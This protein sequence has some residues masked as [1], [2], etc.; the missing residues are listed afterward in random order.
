MKEISTL[1]ES[2]I[3]ADLSSSSKLVQARACPILNRFCLPPG[4]ASSPSSSKLVTSWSQAGHKL[5]TS[6]LSS[7]LCAPSR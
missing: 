6:W 7:D 2:K 3:V 5:V 4:Q 1:F